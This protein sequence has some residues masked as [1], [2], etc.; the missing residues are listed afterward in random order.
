MESKRLRFIMGFYRFFPRVGWVLANLAVAA[1]AILVTVTAI[2][3]YVFNWTPGWA[4]SVCAFLVA[5]AVFMG[6]GYTLMKEQHVRITFA[7]KKLP[8]RVQN[9]VELVCGFL[10]L[11]YVGYLIYSTSE[12]ALMSYR[13][14]SRTPDGL[15][16]SPLQIF[17]PIGL[18]MLFVALLGFIVITI[19]KGLNCSCHGS[20]PAGIIPSNK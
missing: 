6:A 13:L 9:A 10:A 1:M 12:L 17:L 3:R 15:L 14:N 16:L 7:F 5:F 11:L 2:S 18:L 4:D 20:E 19:R 8:L